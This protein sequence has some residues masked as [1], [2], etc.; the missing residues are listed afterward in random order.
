MGPLPGPKEPAPS[1]PRFRIDRADSAGA[2][3]KQEKRGKDR[4][5]CCCPAA[6][7]PVCG[8]ETSPGVG[9]ELRVLV[10]SPHNGL[11]L[12]RHHVPIGAIDPGGPAR[13]RRQGQIS[14]G[15][16]DEGAPGYDNPAL[17]RFRNIFISCHSIKN[18]WRI[19]C[20]SR[21]WVSSTVNMRLSRHPVLWQCLS[22]FRIIP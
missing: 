13:L 21:H 10:P 22:V 11:Y 14:I 2:P 5:T 18:R 16:K 9:G 20:G 4:P 1:N 7:P 8:H 19:H 12:A 3:G 17:A 6:A 15:H